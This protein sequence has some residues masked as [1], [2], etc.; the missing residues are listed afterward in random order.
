MLW[1]FCCFNNCINPFLYN[2]FD[3]KKGT[4]CAKQLTNLLAVPQG[5][6]FTHAGSP[7]PSQVITIF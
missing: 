3:Y 6:E 1:V 7:A 2:M 5:A 4:S